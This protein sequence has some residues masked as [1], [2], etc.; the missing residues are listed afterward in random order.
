MQNSLDKLLKKIVTLLDREGLD[1]F[2]IGGLAVGLLGE[3]RMT[4]DIDLILFIDK[5]ELSGFLKK[6]RKAGFVFSEKQ[7][8]YDA[9]RR[10]A[11]KLVF[12]GL[13][14]D[15]IIASTEFERSALGRRKRVKLAGVEIFLP[16][17]EDFI[18]LKIVPGR[19]K[20]LLDAKTV[21]ERHEGRLDKKYLEKWA[22]A[23]SDEA[24]DMRIW[25]VLKK[26]IG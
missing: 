13:W 18:L 19:D 11:F 25:T 24:E 14:V 9:N 16:S 10:G 21:V 1:Y 23:L 6:A 20:D 8:I 5:Q 7:A 12:C 4:Q 15:I 17:P 3:P 22:Q 2:C 26:L